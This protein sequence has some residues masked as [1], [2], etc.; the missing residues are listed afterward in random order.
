MRI[1]R[2]STRTVLL[3]GRWAVKCPTFHSWKLFL[4]GLLCNIQEVEF[5]K[6]ND[7]RLM[8]IVFSTWGGFLVVMPRGVLLSPE[9]FFAID[10]EWLQTALNELPLESKRRNFAWYNGRVVAID[11]GS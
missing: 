2:G 10:R 5:S 3:I 6:L 8:P 11:Y 1:E 4:T 7:P 9:E